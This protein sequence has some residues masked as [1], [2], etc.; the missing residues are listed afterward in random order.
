MNVIIFLIDIFKI[1]KNSLILVNLKLVKFEFSIYA[2][3]T[4]VRHCDKGIVFFLRQ[5]ISEKSKK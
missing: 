2:V 3:R 5:C 4:T 1:S